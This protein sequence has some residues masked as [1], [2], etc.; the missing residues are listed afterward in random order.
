MKSVENKGDNKDRIFL[1]ETVL[2]VTIH[3]LNK[4]Y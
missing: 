1:Y 2:E 3:D 4:I